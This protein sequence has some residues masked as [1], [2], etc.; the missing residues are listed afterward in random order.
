VSTS[1]GSSRTVLFDVVE[2]SARRRLASRQESYVADNSPYLPCGLQYRLLQLA[3]AHDV[4]VP[5]PV[6]EYEPEDGLGQGYV[7]A[8]VAGE[9]LPN[10]IL[11][12]AD[13]AA[14]RR[15]L[16]AQY[17][18]A[19]A[20]LHAI[21]TAR[22]PFLEATPDSVDALRAQRERLD[23]YD[24]D[25]PAL[26][27][28]FRWLERHRPAVPGRRLLHGDFRTG[29]VIVGAEGLR[30]VLDWECSHLGS[31]AE[32][33]GWVCTRSWRFGR[34]DL[35]AGGLGSR[36]A[37]VAAYAA[38]GGT[39]LEPDDLRYWEV[40]GLVRWAVLNVMQAHGHVF[41]ARRSLV[42][43]ACGRNVSTLEYDLLMTLSGRFD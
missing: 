28:G 38:A 10:R 31:P 20:R 25:H 3:H 40:F 1:G 43:A 16:V 36:E 4:P 32:D 30:A 13:L 21:D 12:R 15:R 19:L 8:F 26:E 29:N 23:A 35:P 9:T 18:E 33:L 39:R 22:V 34:P 2:G 14:A 6:F 41:G 17:G 37:L 42:W 24:E 7:T 11:K 5:E 27:L